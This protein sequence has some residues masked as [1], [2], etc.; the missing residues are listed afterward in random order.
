MT[1]RGQLS[2]AS[3]P[4]QPEEEEEEE[5]EEEGGG[6]DVRLLRNQSATVAVTHEDV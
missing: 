2:V 3:S 5:G 1:S 6:G 4:R